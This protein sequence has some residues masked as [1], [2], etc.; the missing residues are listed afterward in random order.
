MKNQLDTPRIQG[1]GGAGGLAAS[2]E[3]SNQEL[4]EQLGAHG[5]MDIKALGL[6]HDLKQRDRLIGLAVALLNFRRDSVDKVTK[7][8]A[9]T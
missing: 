3:A 2:A 5:Q 4:C 7:S 6:N 8:I 9:D 1:T